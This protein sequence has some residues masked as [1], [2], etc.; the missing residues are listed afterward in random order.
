MLGSIVGAGL[1]AALM[2]PPARAAIG[3]DAGGTAPAPLSADTTAPD[4]SSTYGSGNFGTWHADSF[5]LPAYQYTVDEQVDPIAKQTELNG[6]TTTW[7]QVGN[8]Y[9]HAFATNHGYTQLWS[10]ARTYQW[11]N[12]YEPSAKH[13]SGGFGYLRVGDQTISTLYDDR[14]SGAS[15]VRDFGVGYFHHSVSTGAVGIDEYVYAPFGSDPVLLHDVT[16]T[17]ST[18]QPLDTDWYEYWDVNPTM[19]P[20]LPG[21]GPRPRGTAGAVYDAKSHLL[22]VAQLPDMGDANPHTT[23]T[24]PLSIFAEPVDGTPVSGYETSV[25]QFFGSGSRGAPA[26]VASGHLSDTLTGPWV[27][28][29]VNWGNTLF[30]Y[31]SPVSIAPG[32]SVTLRYVYGMAHPDQIA[33]VV[34][35]AGSPADQLA[36]SEAQWSRWLPEAYFPAD[37]WLSR[38]L[39]WDA[40]MVRSRSTPEEEC[41]GLPILSQGGGY[42]YDTGDQDAYRDPLQHMLPMVYADPSLA[43][44]VIEYSAREQTIGTGAIPY[45]MQS[46]CTPYY[47]GG[48][49]DDLDLWLLLS[50]AEYGLSSRDMRFFDQSVPYAGGA[51]S[52][53]LWNHLKLAWWHQENVIGRGI[54]GLPNGGTL[55]DWADFSAETN[56]MTESTLVAAQLAY[57]YPYM[58]QLAQLKGDTTF[59][60]QLGASA[61]SIRAALA[62]Q[63]EPGGW[64][65]RGYSGTQPIGNTEI[66]ALA[67]PWALLSGVPAASQAAQVVA[68]F[69]R[70]LTGVGAPGGPSKIGSALVPEPA[71]D[72]ANPSSNLYSTP[73]GQT[74]GDAVAAWFA[75]DDPMAWA[76]GT[77]DS[78]VPNADA[79]AWDELT[80]NTL[81]ALATAHPNHWDGIISTDDVCAVWWTPGPYEC[82]V[83]DG[84]NFN[85]Q[86]MHQPAWGLFSLL[87]LTGVQPTATGYLIAP[88]I[89]QQGWYLR[90][91]DVGVAQSPGLLRGYVTVQAPTTLTMQVRV[92]AEM[93]GPSLKV[94]ADGR[95]VA[96]QLS[97]DT[98]VFPLPAVAGQPADWAVTA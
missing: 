19:Q 67:Q 46:L 96:F 24:N 49:S 94:Y 66:W 9:N 77:V 7:H 40:Y 21:Y 79:Y 55:G 59:A 33:G 58:Q 27:A 68:N 64:Y 89:A 2:V 28:G 56:Q 48:E 93:A 26:E 65:N 10:Q 71:D 25:S 37:P 11:A 72:S 70:H 15:T 88:H 1:A 3:S 32:Q 91:P 81:A 80:R 53:T 23:D 17:N 86:I 63:W 44:G 36:A 69:R 50:A 47:F 8:D 16:I 90:L 76:Y 18:S 82:G 83:L 95:A 78:E 51:G 31:Q 84:G 87:K 97:G 39:Q 92:P 42:Q 5:G 20:G 41:G 62:K 54:H 45:A 6:G 12:Y 35:D 52:D 60:T 22:S 98:V 14:P 57:V 34:R 75:I 38:E 13:Y 74:V 29:E 61:R 85:T 4:I 30:A 43:R 73:A